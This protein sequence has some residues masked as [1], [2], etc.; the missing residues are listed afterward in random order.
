MNTEH[1][2]LTNKEPDGCESELCAVDASLWHELHGASAQETRGT[3]WHVAT[4][5]NG[6]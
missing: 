4:Y 2:K 1:N 6:R 5:A 3:L